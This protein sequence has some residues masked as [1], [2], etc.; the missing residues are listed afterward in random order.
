MPSTTIKVSVII[1]TY[2]RASLIAKTM[3]SVLAQTCTDYE[4]IIIDDGSHDNTAEVLHPY[5]TSHRGR[6]HYHWQENQGKSVAL[7][8]ALAQARG[9]FIA[10]LDSDDLWHPEK[11]E[12]QL[13]A[14]TKLGSEHPCFTDANYINNPHLRMTAFEF[15]QKKYSADF[16]LIPDPIEL[17]LGTRSGLY[18]QTVMV[19]RDLAE[20][21]GQFDPKLRVGNDTDYL[22][23]LALLSP[24]CFVNRTL[25]S[26]DRTIN[27]QDGLIEQITI[28]D[29]LRL[30]EHEHLYNKWLELTKT[31][32]KTTRDQ[33]LG[34]LAETHNDWA[35]WHL[36]N[37]EYD[38]ARK[39]MSKA[40][41]TQFTA[42]G[43][44]KLV[45]A[46]L[47]PAIA[48]KEFRRRDEARRR[49]RLI[50]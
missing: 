39:A 18:I 14:G 49:R 10:F 6:I 37:G 46:T 17:F 1:P 28:N 47:A 21:V 43:A 7:N 12:V 5:L 27:R 2:N 24:F 19:R 34:R 50:A 11:L 20:R 8:R 35:N 26:I 40:V 38:K 13:F 31:S 42:K 25:V 45:L 29:H 36:V 15:A 22:F 32:S 23:R 16:G 4:V 9:E 48:R 44:A 30:Q 3:D 33:L 41:V